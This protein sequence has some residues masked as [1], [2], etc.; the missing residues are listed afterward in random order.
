MGSW[1]N[2]CSP[3]M[4]GGEIC[5][6][7]L[8]DFKSFTRAYSPTCLAAM[9]IYWNKRKCLHKERVEIPQDCFGTWQQHG[10]RFTVL[11]TLHRAF[12]HDVMAAI[13]VF[14]NS[15]TAAMLV[16]I[17]NPSGRIWT[18]LDGTESIFLILKFIRRQFGLSMGHFSVLL[19]LC[20]NRTW[21]RNER[22]T[23]A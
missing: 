2:L 18:L 4:G 23:C 9:Q 7:C 1:W 3:G 12:S 13:L 15:E 5:R 19:C 8:R 17:T 22:P 14:Q 10:R 11:Q 21:N 16:S 20:F 6:A